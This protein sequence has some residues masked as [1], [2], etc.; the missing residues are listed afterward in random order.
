MADFKSLRGNRIL[1]TRPIR[2]K[3]KFIVDKETDD[4]LDAEY[5]VNLNRLTVYAVGN[6]VTDINVGDEI[7]VDLSAINNKPVIFEIDGK[8]RILISTFDVILVW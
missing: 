1:V 2:E 5:L 7:L 8:D 3:S 6:L 4:A